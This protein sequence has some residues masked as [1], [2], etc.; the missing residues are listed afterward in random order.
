VSTEKQVNRNTNLSLYD[1]KKSL[2]EENCKVVVVFRQ[3]PDFNN[4]TLPIVLMS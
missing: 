1:L 2:S 3:A 4:H